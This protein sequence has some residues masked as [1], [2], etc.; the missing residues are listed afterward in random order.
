[1]LT[2][3]WLPRKCVIASHLFK[4]KWANEAKRLLQIENIND[5]RNGLLLWKP[6]EHAFDR[7]QF[8][9]TY[10]EDTGRYEDM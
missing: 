3:E 1:M 2:G 4:K 8:F 10:E 9:F 6:L 7:G 5:V